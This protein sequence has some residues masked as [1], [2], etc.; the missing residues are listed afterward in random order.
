MTPTLNF[1][2]TFS[3]CDESNKKKLTLHLSKLTSIEEK[4]QN[5]PLVYLKSEFAILNQIQVYSPF[6]TVRD[7]Y[8]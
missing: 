4:R 1:D 3:K 2:E 8:L 6:V 5:V 7:I